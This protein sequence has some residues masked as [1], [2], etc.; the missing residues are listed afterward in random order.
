MQKVG[1]CVSVYCDLKKKSCEGVRAAI[2]QYTGII[3]IF[4]LKKYRVHCF[5]RRHACMQRTTFQDEH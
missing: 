5:Q 2:L 3:N 4:F 1:Q